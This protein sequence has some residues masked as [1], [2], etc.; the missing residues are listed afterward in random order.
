MHVC[1][2]SVCVLMYASIGTCVQSKI[3]LFD[4]LVED[5]EPLDDDDQMCGVYV[6]DCCHYGCT[7]FVW[8]CVYV[9][10]SQFMCLSLV[11]VCVCV[12]VC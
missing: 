12:C 6:C 4:C 3:G 7:V 1:V 11:C 5:L 10:E 2:R 8:V 9:L